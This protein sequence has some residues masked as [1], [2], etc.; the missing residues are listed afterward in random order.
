MLVVS[1]FCFCFCFCLFSGFFDYS[2][3]VSNIEASTRDN[4]G[5]STADLARHGLEERATAGLA[6]NVTQIFSRVYFSVYDISALN[7]TYQ[8]IRTDAPVSLPSARV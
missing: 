1:F 4:Q 7:C 8:D 3:L 5:R 6:E 2:I